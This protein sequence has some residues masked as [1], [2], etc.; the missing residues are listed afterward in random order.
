MILLNSGL[1]VWWVR[2]YVDDGRQ[3]TSR[4]AIGMRYIKEKNIF[5]V[6]EDGKEEDLARKCENGETD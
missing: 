1:R 5:E 3:N 6:T 2:G 4:M